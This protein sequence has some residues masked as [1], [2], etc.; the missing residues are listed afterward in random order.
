M[1]SP[2]AA[3]P[4]SL[5]QPS[6]A[7]GPRLQS[8]VS[9]R[10]SKLII[11]GSMLRADAGQAGAVGPTSAGR[12]FGSLSAIMKPSESRGPKAEQESALAGSSG[13]G[14]PKLPPFEQP[15]SSPA[16]KASKQD[17]ISPAGASQASA[18]HVK[19]ERQ[20]VNASAGV[21]KD[22]RDDGKAA[23]DEAG[24]RQQAPGDHQHNF[25]AKRQPGSNRRKRSSEPP[26]LGLRDPGH[27]DSKLQASADK[28]LQCARCWKQGIGQDVSMRSTLQL[29]LHVQP[30]WRCRGWCSS[31]AR[32][33][34]QSQKPWERASGSQ[35]PAAQEDC[36]NW[37]D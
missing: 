33:A 22:S 21:K 31:A 12:N 7:H 24:A 16:N 17:D 29:V 10:T 8:P 1:A 3:V 13:D 15:A 25:M 18:E 2:A 23:A 19:A 35:V 14:G 27:I 9:H 36:Q 37:P 5:Q 4:A 11:K 30:L 26:F 6:N 32:H 28:T 34:K 20:G